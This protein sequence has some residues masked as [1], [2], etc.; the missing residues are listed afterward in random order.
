MS[1]K[2]PHDYFADVS[3]PQH[4]EEQHEGLTGA[5]NAAPPVD[6]VEESVGGL[7]AHL[8]G[9]LGAPAAPRLG[10]GD[11]FG[12]IFGSQRVATDGVCRVVGALRGGAVDGYT[13]A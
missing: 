1:S 2:G 8:L 9:G 5:V 6:L 4:H 10:W 11:V 12:S 13:K 7:L 3:R